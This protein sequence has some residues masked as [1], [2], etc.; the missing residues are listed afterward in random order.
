MEELMLDSYANYMFQT[1]AQSCSSEQ[2]YYLLQK[3][4]PSMIRVARDR[5][6]THSLQAIVSLINR[7]VEDKLIKQ[8]LEGHVFEL[9]FVIFRIGLNLSN[10]Q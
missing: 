10:F 1:L 4:A 5:K 7:D 9:A 6:G 3:L 8:T 2:R